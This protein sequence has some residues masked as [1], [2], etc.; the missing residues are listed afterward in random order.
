MSKTVF[1]FTR[2]KKYAE[3][4]LVMDIVNKSTCEYCMDCGGCDYID[5]DY[6][7][8][9]EI[10]L[11]DFKAL[12]KSSG[13]EPENISEL[14]ITPSVPAFNYRT[15][16]QIHIVDGK[17]GYFKKKT[18]ELIEIKNC[19]ML[20]ARLNQKLASLKFP[21][22]FKGKIEL[23]IKDGKV[24]ER[25]VE[26][27]YDNLFFQVNNAVNELMKEHVVELLHPVP[28]DRILELYCGQGNFTYA[29]LKNSPK[30]KVTGIDVNTPLETQKL[31]NQNYKEK[32][33][34]PDFINDD[35]ISAV[36]RLSAQNSL[37]SFN[38]LLLDPP[39]SGAGIKILEKLNKA[40][41]EKII[42]VSCNPETLISDVKILN[43]FGYKWISSQLFDMFPFTKYIESVNSF[44]KY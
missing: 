36:K 9:L 18:H 10:K 39:R 4:S 6:A 2:V 1:L 38:K 5:M 3:L 8:T 42:Y 23:Y 31:P 43:E 29:I 17:M 15:R 30:T 14:K 41:F 35:V 44:A 22:N 20:D 7:Q 24:L 21:S 33:Q 11:N 25:L 40:N 37:D 34:N 28:D 13:L 19:L 12:A 27:K 26:K 16:C 32:K